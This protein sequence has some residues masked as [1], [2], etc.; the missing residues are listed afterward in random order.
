MTSELESVTANNNKLAAENELLSEY[1]E[2]AAIKIRVLESQL[3]DLQ[4]LVSMAQTA[5]CEE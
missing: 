3:S 5:H 4:M 1:A 2:V